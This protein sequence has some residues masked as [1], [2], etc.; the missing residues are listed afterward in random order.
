MLQLSGRLSEEGDIVFACPDFACVQTV[1]DLYAFVNAACRTKTSNTLSS[2]PFKRAAFIQLISTLDNLDA[3]A[4]QNEF[5]SFEEIQQ[6]YNASSSQN[7]LQYL[8]NESDRSRSHCESNIVERRNIL[9]T[10]ALLVISE[11]TGVPIH[12]W[13]DNIDFADLGVDFLLSLMILSRY[14]DELGLND[15]DLSNSPFFIR[16][17]TVGHLKQFIRST[18]N[19]RSQPPA[20]TSTTSSTASTMSSTALNTSS[21]PVSS[22]EMTVSSIS[23]STEA[24]SSKTSKLACPLVYVSLVVQVPYMII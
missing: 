8:K 17:N 9:V 12:E 23:G 10:K 13:T 22:G 2:T 20:S 24:V 4:T 14:R 21:S 18:A 1:K 16:C 6:T 15:L 11:E 19:E 5:K 3:P 7:L